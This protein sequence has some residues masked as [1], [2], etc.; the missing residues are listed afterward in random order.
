VARTI[1]TGKLVEVRQPHLILI[2]GL[3]GTGKSTLAH[4]LARHLAVP[5]ICKDTI[6]EPLLDLL[7]AADRAESRRLSDASFAVVFALARDCLLVGTDVILEG[8]FRPGEHEAPLF[9]SIR[10][11]NTSGR[12]E[13]KTSDP[14]GVIAPAPAAATNVDAA[15]HAIRV[16]QILCRTPEPVRIARLKARAHDPSRHAG[17][18]D[19]DLAD[20]PKAD[21]AANFAA[22]RVANVEADPTPD[23][24]VAFASAPAP[25]LAADPSLTFASAPATGSSPAASDFLALP[26]ERFV[27]ASDGDSTQLQ[28]LLESL[29]QRNRAHPHA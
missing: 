25:N 9:A 12:N 18:R 29:E 22:D 5:L 13:S 20:S 27:F 6:K 28:A 3:P 7:G 16:T 17:H 10:E 26:G 8:N 11:A 15:P 24:T 4:S 19:A 21:H 14:D 1:K 2:T 23:P